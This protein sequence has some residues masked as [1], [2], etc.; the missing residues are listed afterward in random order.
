[1]EIEKTFIVQKRSL[2]SVKRYVKVYLSNNRY[3]LQSPNGTISKI[4][5][6]QFKK[7]CSNTN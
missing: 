3:F 1:M 4:S 5:E 6:K 2:G 7:L